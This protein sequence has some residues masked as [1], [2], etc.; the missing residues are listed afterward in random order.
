MKDILKKFSFTPTFVVNEYK[1]NNYKA[2][3]CNDVVT[4][5]KYSPNYNRLLFSIPYTNETDL[6]NGLINSFGKH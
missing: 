2:V 6:T 5:V 4:I 3:L 1:R